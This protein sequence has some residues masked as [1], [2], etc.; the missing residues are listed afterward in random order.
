MSNIVSH[1]CVTPKTDFC[2]LLP[3]YRISWMKVVSPHFTP[4]SRFSIFLSFP[5]NFWDSPRICMSTFLFSHTLK[6]SFDIPGDRFERRRHYFL[7]FF[8]LFKLFLSIF[9]SPLLSP[10]LPL[11]LSLCL[12]FSLSVSHSSFFG[13]A[14]SHNRPD[15][16]AV[17]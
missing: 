8:S 3:R 5:F 2:K 4:R 11:L 17:H 16:S 15:D 10:L 13:A 14:L 1:L 9:L 6:F 7:I 12:F